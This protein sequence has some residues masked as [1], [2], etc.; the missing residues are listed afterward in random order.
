MTV[1]DKSSLYN[2]ATRLN[3]NLMLVLCFTLRDTALSR[4]MKIYL[5]ISYLVGGVA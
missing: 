5:Y 3:T 2:I 1:Y 4:L